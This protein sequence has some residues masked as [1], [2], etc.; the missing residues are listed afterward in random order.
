L[1]VQG[2][3]DAIGVFNLCFPQDDGEDFDTRQDI[4]LKFQTENAFWR[5]EDTVSSMNYET[6]TAVTNNVGDAA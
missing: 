3:T 6:H 5:V 2:L 4:Y 1:L